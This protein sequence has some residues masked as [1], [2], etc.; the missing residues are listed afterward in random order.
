[1]LV[2]GITTLNTSNLNHVRKF[3]RC[4]LSWREY[5]VI[6]RLMSSADNEINP[7]CR[8][9]RESCPE[10]ASIGSPLSLETL[11][12]KVFGEEL[13]VPRS[14][15]SCL[16]GRRKKEIARENPCSLCILSTIGTYALE[17]WSILTEESIKISY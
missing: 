15:F 4:N 8:C 11:S 12:F 5:C 10:K 3:S 13:L 14:F 2:K 17:S 9:L 16:V 6:L 7:A 1:M